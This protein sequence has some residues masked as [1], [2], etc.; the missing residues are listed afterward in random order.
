MYVKCTEPACQEVSAL[1]AS[2]ATF[3]GIF[4]KHTQPNYKFNMISVDCK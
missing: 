1:E 2:T 4:K 3:S